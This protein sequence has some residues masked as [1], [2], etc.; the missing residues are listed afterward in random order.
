MDSKKI[1]DFY[2]SRAINCKNPYQGTRKRVLCVCSAGLL[3]SPT[4]AWI[5]SNEPWGFNT[6]A[7]GSEREFALVPID[8]VLIQWA[9]L[10]VF[11]NQQNA[12][13]T[14]RQFDISNKDYIV[15][16]IPDRYECRDPEL[17]Q[18][19]TE[20]IKKELGEFHAS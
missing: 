8:E 10:L 1:Q 15:L 5:L 12:A 16:D 20:Q 17:V 9:D 4:V 6:R 13:S 11:V 2:D 14:A 19:A 18:I 3:R 7:V